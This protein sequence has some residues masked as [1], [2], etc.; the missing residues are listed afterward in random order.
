[1]IDSLLSMRFWVG[2]ATG[3]LLAIPLA[4]MAAR[5]VARRVRRLEQRA[6]ATRRLAELGTLTGGLAHEIKNPLSTVGLN[7]QLLQEDLA[8]LGGLLANDG[9][10]HERLGRIQRR[11]GSLQ[12]ETSR[13]R[14]IL[15]DFLQ[16]AGRVRLDR[17]PTDVNGL[18]E[19]LCD[20]FTPQAQAAG[21][22]LRTQLARPAPTVQIDP[23]L[24]K[25]ALLNLM[26]NACQAM[27]EHPGGAAQ[28][29]AEHELIIRT[30]R[31]RSLGAPE[32]LQ[33]HIIDTGPGMD[34]QTRERVFQPYFS[35]KRGG[36]GLG[37][38]TARRVIEEHGGTVTVYSEPGRGSDFLISLPMDALAADT[39]K[40]TEPPAA[41]GD[42]P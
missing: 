12:R 35:G 25:Q 1:M 13:L 39:A 16:F 28:G 2:V 9:D 22:R 17:V 29:A 24:F 32:D 3:V 37:L 4:A 27:G 20:F 38:P 31:V 11:F 15:E 7:L 21:V 8:D 26:I 6:L 42:R 40:G 36:T 23:A 33:V 10:A 30:E 14:E 34:G 5:R 18:I 19:E 41:K